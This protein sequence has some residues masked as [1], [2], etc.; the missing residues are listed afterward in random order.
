[1]GDPAEENT[2]LAVSREPREAR[3]RSTI[4]VEILLRKDLGSL[5][6]GVTTAVEDSAEHVL[7]DGE[8]HAAAC[9]L[10][11]GCL[12]V[13][14]RRALKNLHDGLATRDLEDLPTA[15]CSIGKRELDTVGGAGVS[16]DKGDSIG[17]ESGRGRTSRCSS[18][19]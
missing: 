10:D 8:L 6:D 18:A 3:G 17:A 15:D 2:G 11:M 9:E 14:A 12:D 4:D 19:T 7:G 16:L 1:M 13:D 5:V